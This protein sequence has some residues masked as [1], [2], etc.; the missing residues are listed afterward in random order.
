[1]LDVQLI[2]H[3]LTH[4][5]L[6]SNSSSLFFWLVSLLLWTLESTGLKLYLPHSHSLT[7]LQAKPLHPREFISCFHP[8]HCLSRCPQHFPSRS[9]HSAL[10][11][12][13]PSSLNPSATNKLFS[14]Y[15]KKIGT[16][17]KVEWIYAL[18]K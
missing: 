10:S 5:Y 11:S 13:T 15:Y 3:S 4:S 8:F 6:G 14:F 7:P 16:H 17:I 12:P 2:F 18:Q 9:F 1:M